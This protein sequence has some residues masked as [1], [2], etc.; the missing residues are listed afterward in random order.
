MSAAERLRVA[1]ERIAALAGID[2]ARA[3]TT[4]VGGDANQGEYWASYWASV[5][6]PNDELANVLEYGATEDAAVDALLREL[7]R[8]ADRVVDREE[9]AIAKA[10]AAIAQWSAVRD[11]CKVT[12]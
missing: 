6:W 4:R 3:V 7:A 12:L 1:I 2:I 8:R 9:R 11:A 5:T 10:R